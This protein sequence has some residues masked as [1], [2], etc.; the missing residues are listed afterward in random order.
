MTQKVEFGGKV[1][2]TFSKMESEEVKMEVL[3]LK[4]RSFGLFSRTEI[5]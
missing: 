4:M 5:L 3:G 1:K 2:M